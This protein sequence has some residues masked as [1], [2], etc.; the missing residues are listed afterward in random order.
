MGFLKVS[1]K[2]SKNEKKPHI[3]TEQANYLK[4]FFH[5]HVLKFLCAKRGTILTKNIVQVPF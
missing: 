3:I 4:L 2:E 1:E 5:C